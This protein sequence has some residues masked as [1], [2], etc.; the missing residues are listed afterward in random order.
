MSEKELQ[1]KIIEFFKQRGIY[2]V[3]IITSNRNGVPDII[4]CLNGRFV[5]FEVKSENYKATPLQ[6]YNIEAIQKSGG[7][8]YI[9]NNYEKFL[10]IIG[11][12]NDR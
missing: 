12:I 2:A 7:K 9:V 3:K 1:R 5:A 4:A 10:Q 8:A 6:I 11:G